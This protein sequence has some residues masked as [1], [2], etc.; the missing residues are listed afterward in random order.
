MTIQIQLTDQEELALRKKAEAAG[1]DL[2]AYAASMLKREARR[3][4]R[5]IEQI[6][7]DIERRRGGPLDMT[8]DQISDMLEKA[9]HKKPVM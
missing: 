9:K 7:A 8:D 5:T 1:Q 2:A 3:P 4:V 6:A